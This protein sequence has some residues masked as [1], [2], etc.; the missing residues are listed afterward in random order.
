MADDVVEAVAGILLGVARRGTTIT[1]GQLLDAL[2]ERDPDLRVLAES[3]LAPVLRSVSTREDEAGRGLLTAVVVRQ[4]SGLP[5][6][7]FFRLAAERG[8]AVE[9]RSAAWSAELALVHAAHSA[10]G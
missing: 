6:G 10:R 5:G 4:S 9:D 8:R 2:A 7:G 1:Y 3:D